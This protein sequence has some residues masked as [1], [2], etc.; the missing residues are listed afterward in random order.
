LKRSNCEETVSDPNG[1][2]SL[3]AAIRELAAAAEGGLGEHPGLEELLDFVSDDLAEAE[4]E[5]MAEHLALCRACARTALELA[6]DPGLELAADGETLTGRELAAEWERFRALLAPAS[7][8]RPVRRAAARSRI[9]WALAAG[10]LLAVVGLGW[11]MSRLDREVR[12]LAAPRGD[13]VVADLL[14]VAA[15]E[16]AADGAGEEVL[17]PAW[18]ERVVLLLALADPGAAADYRAEITG[19][20]AGGRRVQGIRRDPDGTLALDLPARM[21]RPGAYRIRLFA[22]G[23]TQPIAEYALRV[24]R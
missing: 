17:V 20:G 24:A 3:T 4:R 16:R 12:R 11:Q 15:R 8:A 13:L 22:A 2:P 18:A 7:P 1:E 21:L 5:R 23:G 10:L 6:G 19:A 9:A 14:P